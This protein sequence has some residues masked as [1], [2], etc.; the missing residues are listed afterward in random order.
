MSHILITGGAGVLGSLLAP[1]L[2]KAGHTVRVMS[3]RDAP[4]DAGTEWARA[5]LRT[6]EGLEAAVQG[7]DTIVHLASSAARHRATDMEGTRYLL[8]RATAATIGHIY[9][10]SIVGIDR[11]PLGYYK[12][13][14]RAENMIEQSGL[15]YSIFRVTQ[16][17]TLIDLLLRG[18][19]RLPVA[20]LP[21]DFRF[22]VVD[23]GEVADHMVEHLADGPQQYLPDMGGPEVRTLG[24]LARAWLDARGRKARLLRLPIPGR[25]ARGFRRGYNC[26][27]N[28]AGRITWEEWL[29]KTYG[30]P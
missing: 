30:S 6:G 13:K 8:E 15:P 10:V 19:V 22:Q 12:A 26:T 18:T 20:L 28:A 29:Q 4:A 14:L 5:D 9:Y 2:Q 3:R 16:F 1:R 23:P 17:H 7:V 11:I 27:E 21:A 24:D 25:V